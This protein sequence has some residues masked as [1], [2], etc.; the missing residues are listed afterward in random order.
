MEAGINTDKSISSGTKADTIISTDKSSS[1]VR[2]TKGTRVQV[3]NRFDGSWSRGFEVFQSRRN[4]Y[5]L[6]RL[7]DRQVLPVTFD[8]PDLRQE[9]LG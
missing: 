6:R 2:L 5:L 8:P 9:S 1:G 4:G 3:R 7:S